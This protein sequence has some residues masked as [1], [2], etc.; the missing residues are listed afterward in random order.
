MS[1]TIEHYEDKELQ[2]VV[3]SILTDPANTALSLIRQNEVKIVPVMKSRVNND[4]EHEQN[5]GLTAKLVKV[6]DLWKLFTDAKFL[7]VVDYYFFSTATPKAR[8]AILH[9]TLCEIDVTVTDGAVK[10]GTKKP[11]ITVFAAT[12]KRFGAFSDELLELR[13]WMNSAKSAA[14][15][16][17]VAK[18]ST[19]KLDDPEDAEDP[20]RV[21]AGVQEEETQPKPRGGRSKR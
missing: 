6:S 16:S 18:V 20:P 19:G 21:H 1:N 14:A 15:A 3:E 17:F 5:P 10:C 8:E 4:G 9:N 12:L 13:D 7:L 2:A 11:E